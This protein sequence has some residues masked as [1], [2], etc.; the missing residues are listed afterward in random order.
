MFI[1]SKVCLQISKTYVN[2]GLFTIIYKHKT[3]QKGVMLMG[4]YNWISKAISILVLFVVGQAVFA[5]SQT[6]T[7]KEK[8]PWVNPVPTIEELSDGKIMT[9]GRLT[10]SNFHLIKDRMPLGMQEITKKGSEYIIHPHTPSEELIIPAL[11]EYTHKYAGQ[12][13]IKA[14]GSVYAKDGGAWYGGFPIMHPKTGLEVMSNWL[15]RDHDNLDEWGNS[16]WIDAEGKPYKELIPHLLFAMTASRVCINPQREDP[17]FPGELRREV[18][19]FEAPYDLKGVSILNIFYQD[20]SRLPDAYAY[21]PVL[22]RVQRLSTA[23]RD[24][25]LDGSDLRNVNLN[26]FNDPLGL[27]DFK[28]TAQKPMLSIISRENLEAPEGSKYVSRING[29]YRDG[30][31]AELRDTF[32][33]EA[34]PKGGAERIYSK[35]V[36]Y[37][38]A[39]TYTTYWG[40]YYDSQGKLWVSG[41]HPRKRSESQCGNFAA[42]TAV[43]YFNHQSGNSFNYEQAH[44]RKF[45][46]ADELNPSMLNVQFLQLQGR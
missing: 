10:P 13:D 5:E 3:R 36:L 37:I 28:L 19:V 14:D 1:E 41:V 17:A 27:W 24:D 34:T 15:Y 29:K 33:I 12:A 6:Q 22:R 23:Q 2:D 45:I 44:N 20:Q 30:Q 40:D 43:E 38:D 7:D 26:L 39:A 46:S 31:I 4:S 8:F 11:I 9:G 25:S 42:L 32:V 35:M 21:V 18:L 16:Q